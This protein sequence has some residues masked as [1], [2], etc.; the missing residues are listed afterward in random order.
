MQKA[1]KRQRGRPVG[2]SDQE[3]KRREF[4]EAVMRSIADNGYK[5]LTVATICEA[6]G[7]SRGL[8]G[9]YFPG[10]DAL[11]LHAVRELAQDFEN[12]TRAAAAAAGRDSFDR[13]HAVVAA[14]FREPVFTEERVLVWVALAST[15]HWSPE[16]AAVYRKLYRPYHRGLARLIK[17]AGDQRGVTVNSERLAI[18]LTQLVE[19]LWSGWAADPKTVSVREA[20]AACHDLLNAFLAAPR[21]AS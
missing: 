9:H 21:T 14:S 12:A 18:T 11:L 3:A 20:E 16:L 6:G 5:D 8:I 17:K 7:F 19:G 15:A 13:L 4:V 1:A 10:K 2:S